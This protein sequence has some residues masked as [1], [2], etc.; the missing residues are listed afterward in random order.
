[1][2]LQTATHT[3]VYGSK[4][5]VNV[6]QIESAKKTQLFVEKLHGDDDTSVWPLWQQNERN[7]EAKAIKTCLANLIFLKTPQEPDKQE[8]LYR[9]KVFFPGIPAHPCAPQQQK[10][11]GVG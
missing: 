8:I 9:K 6:L 11:A 7:V 10:L 2:K 3:E 1:M 4:A 5:E